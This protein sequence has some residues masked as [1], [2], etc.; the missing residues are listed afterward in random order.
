MKKVYLFL[1]ALS[2]MLC[3]LAFTVLAQENV[4]AVTDTFYVV[5]SQDSETAIEL[6][7]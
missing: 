4:P 7:G 5:A 2:A 1:I 3:L 6:K